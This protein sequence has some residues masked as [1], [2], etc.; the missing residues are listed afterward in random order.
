MAGLGSASLQILPHCAR[1]P[2]MVL[3]AGADIRPDATAAFEKKYG[4][5]GF[6]SI[7]AMCES[8]AVDAV[9]IATP[10]VHHAE[11]AVIAAE[12]GKHVICEKPMAI[13]MPET[14]RMIEA[15]DRNKVR[16]VQG[17]S[18]IYGAGIQV[19]RDVVASGRLGKVIQINTWNS[20][21]WLQRPRLPSEVDTSV[22]GGICFRQGPHQVDIVRFIGGGMVRSVRAIT[23]RADRNFATEGHY[24]AFLDFDNG[25]AATLAFNAYG[26]FDIT[27]LTWGIG[28][29]G[30]V[31]A[32]ADMY[33]K[34]KRLTGAVDMDYKYENPR[35]DER[36][37]IKERRSQAFFGLTVVACEHGM[38]RQSPQGLYLYTADGR[39]EL[40]CPPDAGRSAEL[41]ELQQAI[42]E[43]RPAFPDGRWGKATLEVCIGM[44]ESSRQGRDVVM[45]HQVPSA[46]IKS[47]KEAAVG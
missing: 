19:M 41:L 11:H 32:E 5:K 36:Q 35:T 1:M 47:A 42:A 17:H 24:T 3:A 13:T 23:G 16:L 31:V 29:G 28:E 22:G 6:T 25:A 15:A 18:K 43:N 46:D 37:G 40:P 33:R 2:G 26:F 7:K 12:C 20:N 8:D 14:D 39:E 21:D 44:L 10:N 45:Q 4:G 30:K 38:I 34:K 9:W 27:E